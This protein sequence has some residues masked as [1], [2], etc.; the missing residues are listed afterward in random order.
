[1]VNFSHGVNVVCD[2]S[3]FWI[4]MDGKKNYY[5]I[6]DCVANQ[7]IGMKAVCSQASFSEYDTT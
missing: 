5:Y 3:L 2:G 7:R 4:I 6:N 1:M